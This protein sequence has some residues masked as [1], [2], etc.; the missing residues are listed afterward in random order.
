MHVQLDGEL[1]KVKDRTGWITRIDTGDGDTAYPTYLHVPLYLPTYLPTPRYL[2]T[3]RVHV[4]HL[5]TVGVLALQ[6]PPL[7]LE[8]VHCPPYSRTR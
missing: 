6:I 8:Y 5:Q 3:L 4:V 2:P 7:D 1:I